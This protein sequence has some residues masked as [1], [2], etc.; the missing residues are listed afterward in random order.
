MKRP[1]VLTGVL[2]Q[3]DGNRLTLAATDR[4]RLAVKTIDVTVNTARRR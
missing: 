3:I 4:H 2:L 1:P